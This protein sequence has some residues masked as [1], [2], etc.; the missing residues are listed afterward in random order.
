MKW[1]FLEYKRW[2]SIGVNNCWPLLV[3]ND[4]G[5]YLFKPDGQ[6][7]NEQG[8][9]HNYNNYLHISK[10]NTGEY[11]ELTPLEGIK[12]INKESRAKVYKILKIAPLDKPVKVTK[13]QIEDI[14]SKLKL[15][16]AFN[17][18]SAH[19]FDDSIADILYSMSEKNLIKT[20]DGNK[21]WIEETNE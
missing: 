15:V 5:G 7:D 3:C 17:G 12:L 13:E 18:D 9:A 4:K 11:K 1:H 6:V 21:Y 19:K 16:R 2:R 10:Y 14:T 20:L 8:M